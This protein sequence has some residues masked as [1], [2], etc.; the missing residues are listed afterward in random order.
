M[1]IFP[2]RTFWVG[3]V[4]EV[5]LVTPLQNQ[6]LGAHHQLI[7][8]RVTSRDAS[9]SFEGVVIHS[10]STSPESG[11]SNP[12]PNT[13]RTAHEP[14]VPKQYFYPNTPQEAELFLKQFIELYINNDTSNSTITLGNRF[15]YSHAYMY[16]NGANIYSILM[17]M[18][19][20][21]DYLV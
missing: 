20:G 10:D 16:I 8:I 12:F 13:N 6:L 4:R 21:V 5:Q 11:Y 9:G 18:N 7:T 2:T 17:N 19:S 1:P 14:K 15:T 3:T